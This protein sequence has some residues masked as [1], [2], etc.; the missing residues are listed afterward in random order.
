MRSRWLPTPFC[1]VVDDALGSVYY[2]DERFG[3]RKYHADPDHPDAVRE[4]AI[5]GRHGYQGD[6]EGLAVYAQADGT[7][8]IVSVD[9]V[10]GSSRLRFYRREGTHGDPHDHR[11][12]VHEAVTAS[13]STDGLE[14]VSSPLPGFPLGLAVLMHS[15]GR[16]F[17]VYRWE[18]LAP[19]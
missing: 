1:L 7:G 8:F 12:V 10:P 4:L 5:F 19:R 18:G 6:R 16:N 14:V 11:E 3:I 15:A 17:H 13:D 2:A 9:Q